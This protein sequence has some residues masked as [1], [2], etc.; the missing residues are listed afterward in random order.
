MKKGFVA[1]NSSGDY[2]VANVESKPGF[3]VGHH[4]SYS[5]CKDLNCATVL[6]HKDLATS[7]RGPNYQMFNVDHI[8]KEVIAILPVV[9]TRTLILGELS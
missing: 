1:I 3:G 2:L 5:W 9:E 4:V 6:S 8:N 7:L